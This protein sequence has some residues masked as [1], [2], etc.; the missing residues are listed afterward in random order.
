MGWQ[1]KAAREVE[2][3]SLEGVMNLLHNPQKALLRSQGGPLASTP[4]V[5]T[6]VDRLSRIESQ[7]FQILL[8]RRLRQPLPLTVHSCRC[9]RLH[10]SLGHHRSACPVA[11]VL[12]TR[13]FPLESAAA[14]VCREG[15]GRVRLWRPPKCE[16]SHRCSKAAHT[17]AGSV[18]G[19]QC[20]V[21]QLHGLSQSHSSI[22]CPL[23]LR[24]RPS[25]RS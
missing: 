8:L 5:A 25:T 14:R 12:E 18:G 11:G 9:G 24:T 23:A 10:D 1:S 2:S 17:Q 22:R 4:F 15:G 6:P 21:A 16:V 3:R 19:A 7:P 13:G 20:L